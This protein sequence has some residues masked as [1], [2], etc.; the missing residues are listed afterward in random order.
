MSWEGTPKALGISASPLPIFRD[1]CLPSPYLQGFL[2]KTK[3]Q[4][5]TV[6]FHSSHCFYHLLNNPTEK[7]YHLTLLGALPLWFL[8]QL[9][10]FLVI[11]TEEGNLTLYYLLNSD[12]CPKKFV[13][14]IFLRVRQSAGDGDC[15]SW[16]A[17]QTWGLYP[18]FSWQTINI[19]LQD[20]DFLNSSLSI[21]LRYE[22][23]FC[24]FLYTN[25]SLYGGGQQNR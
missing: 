10:S 3:S 14:I 18:L 21:W 2:L 19:L 7:L 12:F 25:R 1:F 4:A 17:P 9:A 24:V 16:F 22:P 6:F 8:L 5:S 15:C 11:A 20:S 13:E 23:T